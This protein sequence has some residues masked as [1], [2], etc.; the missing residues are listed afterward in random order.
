MKK[1]KPSKEALALQAIAKLVKKHP[2]IALQLH[3][4]VRERKDAA[5]IASALETAAT[6]FDDTCD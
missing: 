4:S 5:D 6:V 2:G 3:C 1:R